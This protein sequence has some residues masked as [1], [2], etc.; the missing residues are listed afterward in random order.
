MF[1]QS[2]ARSHRPAG[3]QYSALGLYVAGWAFLF[4]PLIA[5]AS[6]PAYGATLPIAAGLTLLAF[7][8]LSAFVLT[9]K[10]DLSFL[11]PF[12]VISFLVAT[13]TIVLGLIFNFHLGVWFSGAMILLAIGS[14]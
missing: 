1:A 4:S 10:K 6:Q 13:A 12:L 8:A 14:I 5:I 3:T 9:T 7:G 2:M 11:R